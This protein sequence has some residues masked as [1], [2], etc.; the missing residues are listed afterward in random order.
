MSDRT[1]AQHSAILT[2]YLGNLSL[3]HLR[4]IQ[5]AIE[6]EW[7]ESLNGNRNSQLA[8]MNAMVETVRRGVETMLPQALRYVESMIDR[9]DSK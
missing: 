3:T 4:D 1:T 8:A 9:E 6:R 2:A 7:K 5:S